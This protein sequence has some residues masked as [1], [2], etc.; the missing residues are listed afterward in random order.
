MP[1]Q[2]GDNLGVSASSFDLHP[3]TQI[4]GSA[5]VSKKGVG[6]RKVT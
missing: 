3:A 5:G 2:I 4:G 1:R 6:S